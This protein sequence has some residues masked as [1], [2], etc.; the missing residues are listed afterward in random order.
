MAQKGAVQESRDIFA[1]VR[2]ATADFPDV[3][4]NIAHVYMEQKQYVAAIQMYDNCMKKFNRQNDV[5][6]LLYLA[7]AHY[8]A[9]KLHECRHILEKVLSRISSDNAKSDSKCF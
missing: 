2:E 1:Q 3:W 6:L 9:G 7:R 4:I 8:R 5:A